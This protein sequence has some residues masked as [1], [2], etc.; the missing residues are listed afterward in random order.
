MRRGPG[1]GGQIAARRGRRRGARGLGRGGGG[2]A[3]ADRGPL[4][5]GGPGLRHGG[6]VRHEGV[7]GAGGE[8]GREGG[9][10]GVVAGVEAGP[11]GRLGGIE[12]AAVAEEPVAPGAGSSRVTPKQGTIESQ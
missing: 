4:R 5:G 6:E 8:D 12:P 3:E 2:R 11:V 9:V 7:A 1:V 10:E